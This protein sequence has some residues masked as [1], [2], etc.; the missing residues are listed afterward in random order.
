MT[1]RQI[2]RAQ[3]VHTMCEQVDTGDV[4]GFASWFAADAHYR[5]GNLETIHGRAAIADA[6]AGAVE[7]LPW[8]KH[9]VDQVAQIDDQLFCRFTI[10]TASPS[11]AVLALPCVTVIWLDP[12]D[13]IIDYRVHVDITPATAEEL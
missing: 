9:V 5:F 11:G 7:S 2:T 4:A 8:V 12:D 10:N 6:T 13:Q 3:M 1:D